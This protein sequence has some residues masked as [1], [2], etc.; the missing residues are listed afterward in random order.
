M[1]L[2]LN[3][4]FFGRVAK[5]GSQALIALL[6]DLQEKNK[7]KATIDITMKGKEY[8]MEPKERVATQVNKVNSM[9]RTGL[10]PSTQQTHLFT[11]F[12]ICDWSGKTKLC[13]TQENMVV[14]K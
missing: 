4:I 11:F 5:T 10:G 6:V 1:V 8:V 9:A 7:F 2:Y 3:R 13:T 12:G 14:K